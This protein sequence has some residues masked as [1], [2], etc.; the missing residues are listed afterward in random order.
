MEDVCVIL[1][2]LSRLFKKTNFASLKLEKLGYSPDASV[3]QKF[4]KL[5][6]QQ[7]S[8]SDET[9]DDD[10]NKGYIEETN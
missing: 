2:D 3:L 7:L 10:G 4:W 6:V 1:T 5:C 9:E 8:I